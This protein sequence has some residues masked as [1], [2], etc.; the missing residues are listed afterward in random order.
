MSHAYG[1][2]VTVTNGQQVAS[3]GGGTLPNRRLA[4]RWL[5]RQALRLADGHGHD[6][7]PGSRRLPVRDV[8]PVIFHSTDAPEAL[9][10]WTTDDERQERALTA[11]ESG[12]P[13]RL[14][15]VDPAVGLR[16]TLAGWPIR[17]ARA[18]GDAFFLLPSTAE[19]HRP[20]RVPAPL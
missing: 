17:S 12:L 15:V 7:P 11:L 18:V 2:D 1:V 3:L 20:G 16:V 6:I 14:T 9:R 4:L 10:A 13:A 5:R 19:A 8:D